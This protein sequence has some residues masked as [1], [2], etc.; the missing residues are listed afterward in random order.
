MPLVINTNVAALNA[1]R[2]LVSSGYD[3]NQ[4]MERLSSGR[5]INTA[6]DDAAGL[7][8]SNR[9]TSQI[10]GLNQAIRNASDGVP[11]GAATGSKK[12]TKRPPTSSRKY[13]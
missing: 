10:R 2:Q 12:P 8:I 9:Q 3:L 11:Q 6:G 7:A 5:R 4:A 13:E 1:Q